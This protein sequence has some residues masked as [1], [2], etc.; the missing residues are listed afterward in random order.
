VPENLDWVHPLDAMSQRDLLPRAAVR[1]IVMATEDAERATSIGA[2]LV[3]L[4]TQRGRNATS[5]VVR[6]DVHGWNRALEGGLS[7]G[8]E[9]LVI[10]TSATEPWTSGH[11]DPLLNAVDGRDH[12]VGRRPRSTLGAIARR[13]G[14]IPYR[15]LFAVPISDLFSP[16]RIHRRE[17]LAKI[18]LQSASRF[19]DVEILAK[20]TFFVQTIEEVAVPDLRSPEIGPLGHDLAA[21]FSHA[22]LK[23]GE[24]DPSPESGPAEPPEGEGEG[25]DRPGRQD[26]ERQQDVAIEQAGPFEHDA[27]QR[28]EEL[29]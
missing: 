12:V 7:E 13:L 14:A 25:D 10:V 24:D 5:V 21:V 22:T 18:P 2:G 28:L 8:D 23:P 15:V 11:L 20:A 3:S 6:A 26:A 19:L 29:G 9:P 27:S 17:A 4:L 16:V 1:V